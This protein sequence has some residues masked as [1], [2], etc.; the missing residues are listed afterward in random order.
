MFVQKQ[1]NLNLE[2]NRKR[3]ESLTK[4][5]KTKWKI[6]IEKK[7]ETMSGEM[8]ILSKIKRN[9]DS[10]RRKARKIISKY[11]VTNAIDI[12]NIKEKLK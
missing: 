11:K 10:K 7:I 12:P 5:K 4:I 6:N 3:K 1:F 9:K 8:L 2:L